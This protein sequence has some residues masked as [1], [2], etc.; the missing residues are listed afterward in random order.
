MAVFLFQL[1]YSTKLQRW[2]QYKK[3]YYLQLQAEPPTLPVFLG[4]PNA[5]YPLVTK[6]TW[7]YRAVPL[8]PT[9]PDQ[10]QRIQPRGQ[11]IQAL[12]TTLLD[13]NLFK[14]HQ[15]CTA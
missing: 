1:Y 12:K 15:Q 2:K 11:T 14:N 13:C 9:Q 10:S 3:K 5:L 4:L 6:E 8:H 7:M